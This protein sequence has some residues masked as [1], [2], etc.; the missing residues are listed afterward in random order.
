MSKA[1]AM[2]GWR[3]GYAAGPK[4]IVEAM[5]KVQS[6]TTSHPASMAQVAGEAALRE[7]G[8]DVLR[9]AA[10]LERRRDAIVAILA[11]LPGLTC[12]PPAGAF[13]VFPNVTGLFGRTIGGRTVTCGQDVAEALLETARVAVVPGEAFGSSD[14]I[15]ISFSCAMD[16]IEEGLRRMAEAI[17]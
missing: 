10:E 15:R 4:E 6:H 7:A 12:V 5:A 9:M 14:H 16:R 17:A 1:F 8:Q 2:T 13:Y 11:R 3:L